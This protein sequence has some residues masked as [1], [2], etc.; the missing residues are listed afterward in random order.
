MPKA[1]PE[2][3]DAFI[4]A[5]SQVIH[6]EGVSGVHIDKLC[7]QLG[8]SKGS[9]YWYFKNKE[10]L[11]IRVATHF[12]QKMT[13]NTIDKLNA[14]PDPLERIRRVILLSLKA[15]V[16]DR[17][18][19]EIWSLTF[20]YPELKSNLQKIDQERLAYIYQQF[21]LAREHGQ[22]KDG[23]DLW[24]HSQLMMSVYAGSIVRWTIDPSES[25]ASQWETIASYIIDLFVNQIMKE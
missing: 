1:R 20:L 10:D 4:A 19:R 14:L 16:A 24:S 7:E 15:L 2:L 3:I 12:H 22:L 21:L 6:E 13:A 23:V 9:F 5:A 11:L 18:H 8:V 25:F 17:I